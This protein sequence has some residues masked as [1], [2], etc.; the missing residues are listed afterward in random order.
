M[1]RAKDLAGLAALAGL[2]YMLSKKG[3]KK[4]ADTGVDSNPTRAARPVSTETR[5]EAEAPRRQITDYMAKAPLDDTDKYPSGVMGGARMADDVKPTP[6]KPPKVV[7][8]S[9][10]P[11]AT[12]LAPVNRT[13]E[14]PKKQEVYDTLNKKSGANTSSALRSDQLADV[15]RAVNREAKTSKFARGD[16]EGNVPAFTR[17]YTADGKTK[18]NVAK[19]EMY[20]TMSKKSGANTHSSAK[21]DALAVASRAARVADAKRRAAKKRGYKSG[22]MVAKASPASSRADGIASKGKTRGKIC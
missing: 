13:F 6:V 19:Q 8:G 9:D 12:P 11:P 22:G 2:G 10:L 20:D 15:S 16:S 14:D 1:A 4:E 5:S 18:S 3:D 17:D 7:T 21:T